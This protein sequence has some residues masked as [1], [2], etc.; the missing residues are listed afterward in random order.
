MIGVKG[1]T[2][3][4]IDSLHN[5]A[6]SRVKWQG[7]LSDEF[8]ILQGVRQGG[9]LSAMEYKR[10]VNPL[11][12]QLQNSY[13]GAYIGTT[14]IACP[15]VADDVS[16]TATNPADLQTLLSLAYQYSRS[17]KYHLQPLKCSVI[18]MNPKF[19]T[20]WPW[21]L[22]DALLPL[23]DNQTHIGIIRTSKRGGSWDTIQNNI[24]KAT[25]KLYVMMGAG[26]HAKNG[27]NPTMI[28]KIWTTYIT[29][30]LT[31]GLK[32]YS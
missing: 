8:E 26:L 29:P 14:H 25:G 3:C 15:T 30:I 28:R 27:L 4:L 2:W 16:L 10:Y 31:Y 13:C 19:Q 18:C 20:Q 24:K 12:D 6:T 32:S 5:E 23:P 22:G 17:E 9:I 11:L 7:Q 1:N 21:K